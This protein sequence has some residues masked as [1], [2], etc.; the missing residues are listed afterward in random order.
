MREF[1]AADFFQQVLDEKSFD[2]PN[3]TFTKLRPTTRPP[4]PETMEFPFRTRQGFAYA[5]M[6][7]PASAVPAAPNCARKVREAVG[8]FLS[9]C[10]GSAGT[11]FGSDQG[12]KTITT[13][14][15][16]S[17]TLLPGGLKPPVSV[18]LFSVYGTE[19]QRPQTGPYLLCDEQKERPPTEWLSR[20]FRVHT[21]TA[22]AAAT[23]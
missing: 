1:P 9:R 15:P 17:L 3:T 8:G 10:T 22:H 5:N 12:D 2:L 18:S 13:N 4:A 14:N 20:Q 21:L 7:P 11:M 19:F 16:R 23:H 6:H